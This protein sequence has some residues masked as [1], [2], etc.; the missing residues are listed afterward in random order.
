MR[1][2]QPASIAFGLL[3]SLSSSGPAAVGPV[4]DPADSGPV[5]ASRQLRPHLPE[6]GPL[7]PLPT[8]SAAEA[9]RLPS[10]VT[11]VVLAI[12]RALP[13]VVNITSEKTI[14]A[15]FGWATPLGEQ[16]VNGMGSGVIVDER[17]YIITNAHVVQDVTKLRI[18]LH[19]GRTLEGKVIRTDQEDD[20]A[21]VKI[22]APGPLPTIPLSTSSDLMLGE[23]VIAVGNAFG[24]TSSVTVGIVSALG[25]TVRVNDRLTYH[26]LIQT[27]A[28]I[29]PGN[30]GGALLNI[31]GE[32][33]GLNV[34][35]RAGA[36]GI[37]FAIP[38]DKVRKV[39]AELLSVRQLIGLWH[40]LVCV[41][42]TDALGQ[43]RL[44]VVRVDG[45]AKEAGLKDGDLVLRVG[46]RPVHFAL[47]L[48]RYMLS[49]PADQPVP[50]LVE[51][52]G[53]TERLELR[54]AELPAPLR[55]P[56]ELV[57]QQ[58]GLRLSSVEPYQVRRYEPLLRGGMYV[59]EVRPSSVA[60]Q[61]GIKPADILLGL[62]QWEVL[63]YQDLLFVLKRRADQGAEPLR[64]HVLR[65]G[66]RYELQMV[67][68]PDLLAPLRLAGQQP[69]G[70][71]PL[72][73]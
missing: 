69:S 58:L 25:R 32:L 20:L 6:L 43:V 14:T 44:R 16:R 47:D 46:D 66:Q 33:V 68:S 17:G 42:E 59:L 45:P 12:R 54:L 52:A 60:D 2:V 41:E 9:D 48:E 61:A 53:R 63:S 8:G 34:A 15:S 11:P 64:V 22:D 40:G 55:S 10:R 23:T 1:R 38:V 36:Q 70:P 19:D 31:R 73:S 72:R 35:I 39:A 67:V 65:N 37:S 28:S 50:V 24:Y 21:L 57:W 62:D 56:T 3:L 5:P 13:A 18:R 4:R 29:N 71:A 51:R 30:S 27:D 7:A 49:V 26:D